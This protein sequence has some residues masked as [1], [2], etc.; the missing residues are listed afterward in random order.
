LDNPPKPHAFT[1]LPLQSSP[2]GN[3]SSDDESDTSVDSEHAEM[4]EERVRALETD[5]VRAIAEKGSRNES[6]TDVEQEVWNNARTLNDDLDT[7]TTEKPS[8]ES[9]NQEIAECNER[10]DYI[11]QAVANRDKHVY[12]EEEDNMDEGYS[13]D[14]DTDSDSDSAGSYSV[15]SSAGGGPSDPGD[16]GNPGGGNSG[17]AGGDSGGGNSGNSGGEGM[18]LNF[19]IS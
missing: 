10:I 2:Y 12:P 9:L 3:E 7:S 4:Y 6:I 1:S 15:G 11:N 13:G 18:D 17:N 19:E 5:E 16:P 8:V 14:S